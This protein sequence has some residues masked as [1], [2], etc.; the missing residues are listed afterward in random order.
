MRIKKKSAKSTEN[1][2]PR[3]KNTVNENIATHHTKETGD[4]ENGIVSYNVSVSCGGHDTIAG[5]M[6]TLTVYKIIVT[7]AQVVDDTTHVRLTVP[8]LRPRVKIHT[9]GTFSSHLSTGSVYAEGDRIFY[10]AWR[11]FP[12]SKSNNPVIENPVPII[13]SYEPDL[14]GVL[15]QMEVNTL[16][17]CPVSCCIQA[18][19][20]LWCA[21]TILW[22]NVKSVIL[23]PVRGPSA[24]RYL[25]VWTLSAF[26]PEVD[27]GRT[28]GSS[29]HGVGKLL[30][31][32]GQ[33]TPASP[34]IG[35]VW[36]Q[37]FT[38]QVTYC[39]GHFLGESEI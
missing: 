21:E 33:G 6:I 29:Q 14:T 17:I 26:H 18:G 30:Q 11:K 34:G 36:V 37:E 22:L 28:R 1:R 24:C 10:L 20:E 15:Q 9:L 4:I 3:K 7:W 16:V 27:D 19:Q 23:Q 31:W 35:P 2:S 39:C 32:V 13:S 12:L 8:A 25:D 5:H 38:V